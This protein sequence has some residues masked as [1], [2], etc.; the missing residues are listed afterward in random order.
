MGEVTPIGSAHVTAKTH[1][2]LIN[3]LN[4]CILSP[5][6]AGELTA[7]MPAGQAQQ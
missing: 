1:L 4:T 6:V 5:A 3:A 7:N 2:R